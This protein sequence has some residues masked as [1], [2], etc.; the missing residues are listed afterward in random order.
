MKEIDFLP[1][2]Y[3]SGQRREIN[4]RTLCVAFGGVFIVM[5]VWN[6][7]AARSISRTEA[8]LAEMAEM[9][10]EAERVSKESS[11]LEGEIAGLRKKLASIEKIDSR[12]DVA[13]VLAELS[14]LIDEKIVVR[15]VG[16]AAEKFPAKKQKAPGSAGNLVKVARGPAPKSASLPLGDVRFKV[17]LNGLAADGGEVAALICKLE[18]SPYFW[19][20]VLSFCHN[21]NISA[22]SV[23]RPN[24]PGNA[25]GAGGVEPDIKAS[26]FEINCYLANYREL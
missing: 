7:I 15:S 19:Q 25:R 20:V 26:E 17:T 23:S 1:E 8:A 9:R 18:E 24:K 16:F 6:F 3:K 21:K 2:W 11:D 14:F 5:M 13:G 22:A 10:A 4:Y 12:I